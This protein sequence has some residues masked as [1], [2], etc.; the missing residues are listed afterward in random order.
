MKFISFVRCGK[1]GFG[2]LTTRKNGQQAIID[3]TN[4]LGSEINSLQ[5]AISLNKLELAEK[6]ANAPA[7]FSLSDVTL[8]PVIPNPNK[9][10]CIGLNYETHRAETKRPDA[11]YPTI[12]TR[13]AD[14]QVA[15]GQPLIIP[16]V[17][18][19]F[20]YE[21]ELAI[22]IG[23]G[24]RYIEEADAMQHVAGYACYNDA[25]ARDWQRH[26]HQFTPGKTFPATGAFG[27]FMADAKSI[28][29]YTK[30]KIQTRLNGKIMQDADLSQLIFSIPR[31]IAYCS[32]F[33]PLTAGDVIITGTPGGVGDRREPPV[34][35]QA[36]DVVEVEISELGILSNPIIAE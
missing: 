23:Q 20:D 25:T 22:I 2:L 36:G 4:K 27:P 29:D 16:H 6:L 14:S 31:L 18:E 15:D 8:L 13:F 32:S 1:A 5:D 11:K 28:G 12:F 33:T 19:R 21:G 17:S 7:D 35:M 34:Y 26:T 10:L 24:G 9:I 3:L 30:L